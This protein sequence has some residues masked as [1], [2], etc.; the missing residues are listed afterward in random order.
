MNIVDYLK[1]NKDIDFKEKPFNEI[2]ALILA[3]ASYF[4]F[5]Q[6]PKKKINTNS[7]I[8][9]LKEYTPIDNERKRQEK[10][11]FE[12]MLDSKRYKGIKFLYFEKKKN[13]ESIEQFQAITIKIKKL[14]YISY[15][16][17]DATIVGWRED[18]NMAYLDIVPAEI[19]A[20]RYANFINKKF[21]RK[22]LYIGGHSKGG[23]LAIRA[24]KEL[25]NNANLKGIYSFDGPNFKEDFY[26][27][28]FK[29]ISSLIHEYTPHESIIGRLIVGERKQTIVK[30]NA[31]LHR[32]HNA[33]SW[34]VDDDHFIVE[35]NYSHMSSKLVGIL[36]DVFLN[37]DDN[38]KSIIINTVFDIIENQSFLT[39]RDD[40]TGKIKLTKLISQIHIEWKN[41]PKEDRKIISRIIF[42][43][44]FAL[45]KRQ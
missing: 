7:L 45:I 28:K 37:Y 43:I 2:D 12:L 5:D 38:S 18:F 1:E 15:C 21:K 16:G 42:A 14:V 32:Q 23:R 20:I 39:I 30:S 19:D 3:V 4:P 22:N 26:D 33:Y 35:K 9:F 31:Y 34:L 27:D 6:I 8:N 40:E 24:G 17:T 36:N 13:N 44:V 11:L 25:N 29:K 10:Q 41:I